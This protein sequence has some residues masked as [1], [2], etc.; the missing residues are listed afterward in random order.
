MAGMTIFTC[1]ISSKLFANGGGGGV[2]FFIIH[3]R[4]A[5]LKPNTLMLEKVLI[6]Y[7]SLPTGLPPAREKW[8][9][10]LHESSY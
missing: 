10:F 1:I 9:H 3:T 5:W 8:R 2:V 6:R 7:L 4:Q